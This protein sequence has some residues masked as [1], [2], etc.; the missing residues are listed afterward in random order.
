MSNK[1]SILLP[2][3]KSEKLLNHVF[4]PSMSCWTLPPEQREVIIYDNGGNGDLKLN[5]MLFN[6]YIKL[7]GQ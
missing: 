4:F 1:I 3:Y 7:I 5:P 6:K 2:A